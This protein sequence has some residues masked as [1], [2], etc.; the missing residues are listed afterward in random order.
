M[1]RFIS[2]STSFPCQI[3]VFAPYIRVPLGGHPA[4]R[5]RA[6]LR[7]EERLSGKGRAIFR[8]FIPHAGLILWY[9]I[10]CQSEMGHPRIAGANRFPARERFRE[11]VPA[12]MGCVARKPE[13]L[14][15]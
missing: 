4:E 13:K 5:A 12:D 7:A 10:V 8:R 3:R 1:E 11:T 9:N 2:L 6:D 14:C 15:L